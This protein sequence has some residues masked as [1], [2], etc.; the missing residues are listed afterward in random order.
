MKERLKKITAVLLDED[1]DFTEIRNACDA[2]YDFFIELSGFETPLDNSFVQTKFGRAL[3]PY[4]A[5]LCIKDIIRT[6]QTIRGVYKAIGDLIP[7]NQDRPVK[8]LYAG[9]GPFATLVT[10]ILP[11]FSPSQV[12]FQLLEIHPESVDLLRKIT[13]KLGI[14]E[15][16][17]DIRLADATSFTI[18]EDFQPDIIISET[19]N[20]GLQWEPQ[21]GIMSHLISQL[22]KPVLMIPEKITVAACLFTGIREDGKSETLYVDTLFDFDA[23]I[24]RAVVNSPEKIPVLNEGIVLSIPG[25][26][27]KYQWLI[28]RTQVKI[29]RDI[30][31]GFNESGLTVPLLQLARD[32]KTGF[33]PLLRY[34]YKLGKKPEFVYERADHV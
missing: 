33:P 12:Q 19:M 23:A 15:F 8:I 1:S 11:F 22:P 18:S 21:V 4:V 28:L 17:T 10:P 31:I 6:R 13:A 2:L 5:A 30:E 29:Y 34:R 3:S 27:E 26:D 25:T 20:A 9:S 7:V 24:A 14:H 32:P 16:F